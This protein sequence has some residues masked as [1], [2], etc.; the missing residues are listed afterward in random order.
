[1]KSLRK[2]LSSTLAVGFILTALIPPPALAQVRAPQVGPNRQP[3]IRVQIDPN[4]V[5]VNKRAPIPFVKIEMKDHRTGKPIAPDTIVTLRNGKRVTAKQYFDAIN[6]FEKGLNAIGYSLRNHRT[7]ETIQ[8]MA[9]DQTR[10]KAQARRLAATH[11]G[12]TVQAKSIRSL[13]IE[14]QEQAKTD[15]Q[16]LAKLVDFG[17]YLGGVKYHPPRTVHTTKAWDS[18][19][20]G[21]P[22]LLTVS[23]N[24]NLSL[25]GSVDATKVNTEANAGC[26]IIG[27]DMNILRATGNVSAPKTGTMNAK[28]NA[29]VLGNTI[30]NI[31]QNTNANWT[32]T[33]N[34]SRGFKKGVEWN[35]TFLHI[36]MSV[37]VGADVN[38]GVLYFVGVRPVSA[39]ARISPVIR[40]NVY[41]QAAFEPEIDIGIASAGAE[42]GVEGKLTL[43]N[44]DMELL[45][46]LQLNVDYSGKPYFFE[47]YYGTN[48]FE[49]L[50]GSLNLYVKFCG[51]FLWWDDCSE[52]Y[53]HRLF[54]W[55]GFKGSSTLFSGTNQTYLY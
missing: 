17:R 2:K 43:L 22:G 55:Q 19:Q 53:E 21:E 12:T 50:S 20:L 3:P 11:N 36:P 4:K 23:A 45:G 9:V 18:G 48:N 38:A 7:G 16:R 14:Q 6:E 33:D 13:Q 35:F 42:L 49:A 44:D 54:A 37:E 41:A 32:K 8:E 5:K 1:M 39:T 25:D 47:L 24:A 46:N 29:S 34:L 52:P 10:L 40:S 26:S 31:D 27:I 15:S 30:L 28:I 51:S